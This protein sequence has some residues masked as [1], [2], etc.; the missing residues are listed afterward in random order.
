RSEISNHVELTI[1]LNDLFMGYLPSRKHNHV[2]NRIAVRSAVETV[3]YP[4]RTTRAISRGKHISLGKNH[5]VERTEM[6]KST[7]RRLWR[8][9]TF[10][11]ED[12][13][14]NPPSCIRHI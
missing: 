8:N 5:E 7:I 10:S 11:H 13:L 14:S 6:G 2:M 12:A 3:S 1:H 9:S 4:P